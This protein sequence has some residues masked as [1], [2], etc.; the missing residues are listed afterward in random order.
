M[1]EYW[2]IQPP[3]LG[4]RQLLANQHTLKSCIAVLVI[5][6]LGGGHAADGVSA[7]STRRHESV[8]VSAPT[9]DDAAVLWHD[10]GEIEKLDFANGPRGAQGRPAPPF[11]FVDESPAGSAPKIRV[12]D[13][14]DVEWMVK[15]GEEARPQTF[16]SRLAW[17]LGYFVLPIYFIPSG[18]IRGVTPLKRAAK[19]MKPDGRFTNASFEVYVDSSVRWLG[20]AQSWRWDTNPFVGTNQLNGLKVLLMLL[21][22]WDNKDA[23]DLKHGSNTVILIYPSGEARYLVIDWGASMGRWGGYL[24][25]SKWNCEGFQQQTRD[26]VRAVHGGGLQWGYSGQHTNDF[27]KDIHRDDV[28]WLLA[29]L[30]HITDTQLHDAL[31]SSGAMPTEAD[32]FANALRNRV[33]ALQTVR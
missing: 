33:A 10:P 7:T 5:V 19:Y 8:P 20:D 26:L 15:F 29:Y 28:R 32:C 27:V 11:Q 22:D 6:A 2:T 9:E 24:S 16:A 12:V 25:R 31:L 1:V 14:K 18:M 30:D 21:S 3:A 13:A 17:A 4:R 23:R